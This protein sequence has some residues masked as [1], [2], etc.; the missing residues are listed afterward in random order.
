MHSG[1]ENTCVKQAILKREKIHFMSK[2]RQ[3]KI[4]NIIILKFFPMSL[5]THSTQYV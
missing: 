2:G 1:P 5:T 4:I 3:R